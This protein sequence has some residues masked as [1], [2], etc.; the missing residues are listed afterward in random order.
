[1]F[2]SWKQTIFILTL[3]MCNS[4]NAQIDTLFWFAAPEVSAS[5]GE[6][7]IYLRFM[8]YDNASDITLTQPANG[9]FATINLSIPANSVDSIDLTAFLNAIES[10]VADVASNNGLKIV[11][12]EKVSAF[13]E[14]KSATNKEIFTL[15]GAK[16]LGTNFYTP[17]QKFWD[18]GVTAPVSFSSFDV[19]ATENNTTVLITPRTAITGH[20]QD[21]TYS[22]ILN[23]GQTYSGRDM[24]TSAGT[25]LAGS[26]IS[27]DKPIAIS[28]FS[29]ALSESGCISTVGDQ[30]TSETYTGKNFVVHAGTSGNDRVYILAT[31]NGTSLTI[32]N[33]TTTTTLINWGE[34]YEVSLSDA[35]NYISASKPVYVFHVSGYGCDL[36]G[37]QVPNVYC[38]GT[39]E[40]AFTRTSSDSVGLV[41]YTR[42]GFENQFAL[43][44]IAALIPPGAFTVVPGTAGEFMSAIIYYNTSDV[45]VNSYNKVTNT[46]D[47]FGLAVLNGDGG[48]GSSYGFLSEFNSYPIINAGIDD[49]ICANTTISLTGLVGGG[50]VTGLWSGT[51]FG[52]FTSANDFLINEYVPSPL[53]TL[54]S[55]IELILTTT[56]PCP[57]QKDTLLLTVEPAPIVSASADQTH[58]SNNAI[59]DLAGAVTG[60]ATT[61]I[62]TSDGT[63][64][65]DPD[66]TTLLAQY[67]PSAADIS[68]G[69]VEL[70]LTST[71]FGSC[72][73]ETDTMLITYTQEPIVTTGIDTIY[74]CENSPIASLSGSVT[75]V[76]TTGKWTSNGVGIFSP[77]NLTLNATYTPSPSD[78]SAGSVWLFLQSTSNV[79]CFPVFDSVLISFTPSP[80]VGAGLNMLACTNDA[81]IDLSGTVTGGSTTGIWTGGAGTYAPSDT[82]LITSYSPTAGEIS[83]G[84]IL[85]VLTSTNNG[86]CLAENSTVQINFIA[87]PFANFNFTEECLYDA[88]VFTDFSLP[89]YGNIDSWTW[90]FGDANSST[91]QNDI[92]NYAT[93]GTYNVELIITSDVGCSDTIVQAVEAFEVPVAGFSYTSACPGNQII[94]DFTD[95]ST[96]NTDAI[97]FWYYDFGGQGNIA[98]EDPQQ[99]FSS[100][101]NYTVTH[102]VGTVNGC[103]D[104]TSQVLSIPPTPV[105]G[106]TYNSNNG[107]NIGAVFDFINTST[108]AVIYS[109]DFGDNNGSIE[110]DPSNTYFANGEYTV[111]QYVTSA[112]GCTDSTSQVITINTVTIY[113]DELI[114]NAISP[115]DDGANDVWKLD[116]IGL[117]YPDAHVEIYNEWGQQLFVSDGYEIPWDGRYNDE[118]VPDGNYFYVI[119]LNGNGAK[120]DIH[121]GVLLVLKS[122]N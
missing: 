115:N 6:T 58:C 43:N 3:L 90:D 40:T 66:N 17:F 122:K 26:I 51:G 33:T 34:T 38:A 86:G 14:L 11:A 69:L 119:D 36:S 49:T 103:Y 107:L 12:T 60:G 9:G 62:W 104:T 61:G 59:A 10:P 37:A 75:G 45:P 54:I 97:N 4:V 71:N 121:K 30:I 113:I 16:A 93:A 19:V 120:D 46:G 64:T 77:D 78:L 72:V 80:V 83:A 63:G 89:G 35:I 95:E 27:S 31:Q 47:I 32:D 112:F 53:D 57:V 50:S 102:I 85:L 18:N 109:W 98:A 22:V 91:N 111:T 68:S 25:T 108:N 28:L 87:E 118:L 20:V 74:V 52:S 101:G 73:A 81:A 82:D 70:V 94:I 24:N 1:M 79:N 99:L 7:P 41:L 96:T 116:F 2:T 110:E 39:Y 42:S 84:T 100:N 44:G 15:K 105:A 65:F 92:H 88:S 13:Y 106:F 21:V 56:G 23:E 55:P 29:G 114:P 67:I 48:S 117:L 5:A 76:T 8:T